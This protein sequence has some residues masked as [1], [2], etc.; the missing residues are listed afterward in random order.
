M[1]EIDVAA[2]LCSRL[3]HDLISPVSAV[4]NGMEILDDETDPIMREQVFDLIRKSSQQASDMVQFYRVAFGAGGGLGDSVAVDKIKPLI[5]N[6][7][8]SKKIKLLWDTNI[9]FLTKDS[10]K[11]LLN[12]VLLAAESLVR[13]GEMNVTFE[14]GVEKKLT[15]SVAGK[16][17]IVYPP[18]VEM[19]K[20]SGDK[21]VFE[22]RTSPI[23]LI[24]TLVSS[25]QA[26]ILLD[27]SKEDELCFIANWPSEV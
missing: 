14:D 4:S 18:I 16:P 21:L 1:K 24:L 23:A 11:L 6:F 19:L 25:L 7:L 8:N 3:C 17:L 26:S 20:G 27:D 13:G 2:L 10:N 15:V 9:E 5:E 22:P 12:L